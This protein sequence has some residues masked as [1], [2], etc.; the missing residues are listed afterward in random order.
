MGDTS[1]PLLTCLQ[2]ILGGDPALERVLRETL[3]RG[4]S[5]CV[6]LWLVDSDDPVGLEVTRRLAAEDPR[7]VLSV[8]SPP[9]PG[10]NPKAL[11]LEAGLERVAT[12]FTAVLDDD[13]IAGEAHFTAA[14]DALGAFDA[15]AMAELYTGLPSYDTARVD[16][17]GLGGALLAAFVN[18]GAPAVYLGLQS[19]RAPRSLNGMFYVA[20]SADLRR[21]RAFQ[22]IREFLCDDLALARHVRTQGGRMLQGAVALRLHTS[23][24]GWGAY[25][26]QMHR[27]HLFARVL[28]RSE[29][30]RIRVP[31]V[32]ALAFPPLLLWITLSAL[33]HQGTPVSVATTAL[34]LAVREGAQRLVRRR[35]L[36]VRPGP[37]I[38]VPAWS[39]LLAELMQPLHALHAALVPTVRW[40]TRRVRVQADGRFSTLPGGTQ[41]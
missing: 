35:V 25:V 12:E 3:Q 23:L 24:A 7:V 28:L 31:L 10:V 32:A 8:V 15:P 22:A 16:E 2:P 34:M 37:A 4:P 5:W 40:R 1:S 20:R 21:W 30:L 19:R 29:P 6:Y 39:S 33:V 26:R 9:G 11:K 13:T 14:L 18:D 36:A 38:D 41:P 17:I 27:W